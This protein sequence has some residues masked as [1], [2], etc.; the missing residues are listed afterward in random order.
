MG[1]KI[2]QHE[3]ANSHDL[4]VMA[5]IKE[6]NSFYKYSWSVGTE[7]KQLAAQA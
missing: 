1:S 6:I 7:Q 5:T 3:V 2:Y 4:K